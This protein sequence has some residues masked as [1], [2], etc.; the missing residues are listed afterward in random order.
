MN[1]KEVR[2]GDICTVKGG[3]A[4]KS[5]DFI[6]NGIPVIKIA[7]IVD[8]SVEFNEGSK[9][10]PSN[11]T[12]KFNEYLIKKGD[13]LVALSGATTGKYGMYNYDYNAL[14]NQRVAKI[15]P[16]LEYLDPRYLFYYMSKLQTKIL[17]KA[18]GAAQP[19]ISTNE[20]TKFS[21]PL[22]SIK[23]QQ[24]IVKI[25]DKAIDI[26]DKRKYQIESLDQLTQSVYLDMFGDSKFNPKSFEKSTIND[27]A[28]KVTDGEHKTPK[29]VNSG[30]KLLS[31]RNIKNNYID[32]NAGLDYVSNEEY[33]RIKKRCNPE[34][35]DIFISCSGTIGRVARVNTNEP[36]A[37][38]RSVALIKPEKR[39]INPYYLESYLQTEYLQL[40]M[41]KSSNQSSQAN[42]FNNQI[43]KLPVLVPPIDLQETFAEIK[44]H[45]NQQRALLVKGKLNLEN[46][47]NSLLQRAFKG[48]VFTEK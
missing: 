47:F 15:T 43:K 2:L 26:I 3:Y 27:I 9:Y 7:N 25:L 48:E 40:I 41:K 46:N 4:F 17:Y 31:A 1:I 39:V 6:D 20:I 22:P 10:L 45:I 42:L 13:I 29:R 8:K 37:L 24:V 23:E 19:N 32:Y 33:E 38:V 11:Y 14:L 16:N 18:S 5:K 44:K 28:V 30:I 21:I 36:L 12:D 35:G 34:Y